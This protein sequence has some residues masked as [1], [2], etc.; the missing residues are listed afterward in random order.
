MLEILEI[1]IRHSVSAGIPSHNQPLRLFLKL[2]KR[3]QSRYGIILRL[4]QNIGNG[5]IHGQAFRQMGR[6]HFCQLP[7]PASLL[8]AP[9][10][11]F[12]AGHIGNR[13]RVLSFT[14]H[15]GIKNRF[16]IPLHQ[17]ICGIL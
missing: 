17:Q 16:G 2:R 3:K 15:G 4:S 6:N 7:Q 1:K 10:P 13:S 14:V 12:P 5:C 9:L 8:S 11:V